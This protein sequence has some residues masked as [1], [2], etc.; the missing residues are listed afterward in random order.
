MRGPTSPQD[1][2]LSWSSLLS[3]LQRRA[4]RTRSNVWSRTAGHLVVIGLVALA[5]VGG[6][7]TARGQAT[8][9]AGTPGLSPQSFPFSL[10]ALAQA[11]EVSEAPITRLNLQL[12]PQGL[13]EPIAQQQDAT[14]LADSLLGN[15]GA[16][17]DDVAPEAVAVDPETVVDSTGASLAAP[18]APPPQALPPLE[19]PVPGGSISQY[20]YAGHLGLDIAAPWGTPVVSAGEGVVTF[21]GWRDNG[22]GYVIDIVQNDGFV[23]SYN[24]LGGVWVG[25]G[26]AVGRGEAIGAIGC[27]GLCTGP[28]VHLAVSLGG[29]A[30]N[31]LRYM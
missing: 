29:Y 19:W 22:G 7:V 18:E 17:V 31:P 8:E 24:H 10:V 5:A 25:P 16:V 20:F 2:T 3:D 9:V 21:A 15:Q 30:V 28:H 6:L 4:S 23:V 12:D 27:T 14:N 13:M 11:A 26:Q 1:P